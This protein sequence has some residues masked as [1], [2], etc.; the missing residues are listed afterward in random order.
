V[1]KSIQKKVGIKR[2]IKSD[3]LLEEVNNKDFYIVG[4]GASAGGLEAL[5]VFF[6]NIPIDSGMAFIVIQHLDPTHKSMLADL[7]SDHTKMKVKE[8]SHGEIVKPNFVYIIPP[9]KDLGILKGALQLIKPNEVRTKRKAIDSFFKA[10]AHDQKE[11]SIGIILSGTGNDGTLGLAEI[12]SKGG[13]SLVEDPKKSQFP[14]MPQSAIAAKVTDYILAPEKMP[15]QLLK[16]VKTVNSKHVKIQPELQAPSES[17]LKIIFLMIRKQTG[18]DF[19][20][21]K[22]NTI[23]RRIVKRKALNQID[24]IDDY[25]SFLQNHPTEIEKLYQDF[26]IGVTSFFR[27]KEV[28]NSIE[29]KVIPYLLKNCIVKQEIRIWVCGCSTGEEA[30]SLAILFKEALEKNKQYVKVIIFASDIDK[31]AIS[32]ARNGMYTDTILEHISPDRVKRHFINRENRFQLKKEIREMV[33]FAHHNVIKDPPF[34]KMDL[35]T[36][37]NL[38]IYINSDLQKRIIPLFHYSLNNDGIL[39]LGTSESL[40]DSSNLFTAYD[41]KSKIYK[42]KSEISMRK[43]KLEYELDNITHSPNIPAAMIATIT[44]KKINVSS[45]TEKILL[46]NYAPP[47]VIIDKNNNALYFSGNT[48]LYLEPPSGEASLNILEMAKKGLKP[49]LEASIQEA[50]TIKS[51]VNTYG[52]E[53]KVNDHFQ[54]INLVV[55]P[56]L[57]KETDLGA[58][59]IIF[60]PNDK[61]RKVNSEESLSLS[62]KTNPKISGLEKELKITREHLQTAINE[63]E[64]SNEDLQTTNEEY[65]SSNEELQSTNEEL[66]TSREELQSVNEEL[67]TVNTELSGKIEQLSQANDDLNNLL[68]SIE[69]ATVFLDRNLNIK[70]FTPAAT[71]IFNLIPTDIDR[72]VTHLSS[73]IVYKA[74]ADD[75]KNALKTLA[76]KTA[77]VQANDGTWY[78]MR[79]LP[80]RTAENIIEGVLVTFVDIT[81]QKSTAEKLKNTNEHLHMI[82][83]NLPA[84]PFTCSADSSHKISFVGK[85]C[86][87]VMGFLPEQL[88]SKSSFW[89]NRIHPADKKKLLA[90]FSTIAKKRICD[91]AFRW[92]CADGKYK[93]FVN[94]IRY[95]NSESTKPPYIVGVWQEIIENGKIVK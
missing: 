57:T 79:I 12:K 27:D 10:L 33:V 16:Y 67:I 89:F 3:K 8:A 81:E 18:Y 31:E 92:K 80:Y 61:I 68:S 35:I 84:V 64:T 51:E 46:D 69:V 2:V 36:C 6:D 75:V 13:I 40:G 25:I 37:R 7:L 59:M 93:H 24:S 1:K 63:L 54:T 4:L 87:K 50:R 60:E 38:L 76:I 15:A 86:E 45:L 56:V 19:S 47:S 95:A 73:N 66:E 30:Y 90:A 58:M 65:Q 85:S 49:K 72:P 53:I 21:Y 14:G 62:G 17:Q 55:K 78:H 34:S 32:F 42:K 5:S 23:I 29:K 52:V 70:R 20:N 94:H 11:K 77:D 91:L 83:E 9:N 88:M 39:L 28:F 82:L 44:K 41:S 26:F 71:K 22:T 74:L 43:P 48:G